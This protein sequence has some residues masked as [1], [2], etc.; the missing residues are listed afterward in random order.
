MLVDVNSLIRTMG[1][2]IVE[3][4]DGT[5]TSTSSLVRIKS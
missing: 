2:L 3:L 5:A 4:V 1:K